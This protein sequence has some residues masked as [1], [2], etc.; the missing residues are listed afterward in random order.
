[1]EDL[2]ALMRRDLALDP[3]EALLRTETLAQLLG[4]DREGRGQE[5]GRFVLVDE[6]ARLGEHRHG[7]HVGR[8]D[9]AIAVEHVGTRRRHRFG[10]GATRIVAGSGFRPR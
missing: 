10:G 5:L 4:V 1:M 2:V 9:L 8:Q 7:L 6:A 3:D